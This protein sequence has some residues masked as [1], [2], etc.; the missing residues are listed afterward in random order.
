MY[1]IIKHINAPSLDAI[2]S[3]VN[4]LIGLPLFGALYFDTME[5]ICGIYKI[6]NPNGKVYIGQSIDIIKR[7]KQ[8]KSVDCRFQTKLLRSL[9][10]YGAI[11]HS[12]DIICRCKAVE[13]NNKERY[14]Q[15]LFNAVGI[16][17]LNCM[18]TKSSDKS[19]EMSLETK[20]KMSKSRTGVKRPKGYMENLI[21][22]NTGCKR[23]IESRKKMSIAQT[24]KKRTIESRLKQSKTSTGRKVS[25]ESKERIRN[26]S[27]K[28][29]ICTVSN[30]I[31]RSAAECARINNLAYKNFA[32]QLKNDKNKRKNNTNFKYL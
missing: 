27:G 11:S 30:M 8:Y 2:P 18:Y 5:R 6:T 15:E 13:L 1:K 9:L 4:V 16:D 26:V 28:K 21:F 10:K 19:G 14:Y 22:N 25:E 29:V 3:S 31:Y 32:A 20:A 7:F 23:S 24:G 17:G 12:F